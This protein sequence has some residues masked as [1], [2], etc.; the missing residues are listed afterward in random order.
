MPP[1]ET[2]SHARVSRATKDPCVTNHFAKTNHVRMVAFVWPQT[3]RPC[4]NVASVTWVFIAKRTSM[5]VNR[6]H[7]R[8]VVVAL[9]WLDITSVNVMELDSRDWIVKMTL[10]NV[11]WIKS[12]AGIKDI[13][14]TLRD[15]SGESSMWRGYVW[16]KYKFNFL[17]MQ[18]RRRTLWTWM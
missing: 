6:V 10:M 8:M 16:E 17:K 7:V 18:L 13:V 4:V 15:H 5:N 1:P 3:I 11:S 2:I 14:W 12:S 9:I